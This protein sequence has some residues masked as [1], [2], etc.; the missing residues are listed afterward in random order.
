M[1]KYDPKRG[2]PGPVVDDEEPVPVD[3][4]LHETDA[5]PAAAEVVEMPP[6]R[7]VVEPSSVDPAVPADRGLMKWIAIAAASAAAIALL[8]G[9]RRS[10]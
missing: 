6:V 4:I 2:R 8:V 1:A 7:V 10:R 9:W 5:E 3:E